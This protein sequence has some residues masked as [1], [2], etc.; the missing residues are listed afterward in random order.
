MGKNRKGEVI[1]D[2]ALFLSEFIFESLKIIWI[3]VII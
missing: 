3:R 1:A 2:L